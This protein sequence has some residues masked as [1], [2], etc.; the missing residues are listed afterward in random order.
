[1]NPAALIALVS[2]AGPFVVAT[3]K[4]V[5]PTHKIKDDGKRSTINQ[6]LALVVGLAASVTNAALTQ[7]PDAAVDC[8]INWLAAIITGLAAGAGASFAR[9]VD[10]NF[11]GVA[12]GLVTIKA[13]A[14]K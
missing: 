5:L 13:K 6:S 2:A 12:K 1:M 14:T 3:I 8:H 10:K 11:V 7:C 9:D 4:K